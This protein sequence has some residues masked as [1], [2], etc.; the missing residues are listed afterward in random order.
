MT[1]QL[2]IAQST[3]V[4]VGA[5]GDGLS[6]I[7]SMREGEGAV[8]ENQ[9]AGLSVTYHQV[10]YK[11]LSAMLRREYFMAEAEVV[12]LGRDGSWIAD[13]EQGH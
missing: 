10:R 4:L 6:H 9:P 1:D 8:V 3:D 2:Q 5:D 12:S 11:N 13:M 7:M